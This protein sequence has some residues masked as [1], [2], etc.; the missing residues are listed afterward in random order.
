[1]ALTFE[2]ATEQKYA[3]CSLV[4]LR[5][6]F[7]TSRPMTFIQFNNVS[8]HHHDKLI[9]HDINFKVEEGEFI[10]II[11]RVGTGKSTLLKSIYAEVP[12]SSGEAVAITTDLTRIKQK[13][14]P[15]LRRQLGIIFQ[16]FK[17]LHDRTVAQNLDFV[18]QATGWK[19][20]KERTHRIEEVLTLVGLTDH[21]N[22][23]PHE[24]SGGEQQRTAIARALLNRPKVVL[25]DEPTGNLDVETS[26]AIMQTLR[27][28]AQQGAAI[29]MVTHNLQ[30]LRKYPGI[31]Y[32]CTNDTLVEVTEEYS[33]VNAM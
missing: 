25:A 20:K 32:Q 22:K 15:E 8:I 23:F 11:G 30:L 31:V 33:P 13:Q 16:D 26:E 18:L 4:A 27:T 3:F 10:Y 12:I 28:A 7:P 19:K 24:L 5:T 17:L 21:Q 9:L 14:V 2:I 6:F 29:V 1:M